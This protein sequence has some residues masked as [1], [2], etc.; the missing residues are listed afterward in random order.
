M[1]ASPRQRFR[2]DPAA[3]A[4]LDRR[5]LIL[6]VA[7]WLVHLAI[8]SSRAAV[9]DLQLSWPATEARLVTAVIGVAVCQGLYDLLKRVSGPEGLLR[10]ALAAGASVLA[11]VVFTVGD[12]AAFLTLVPMK[13]PWQDALKVADV[14]MT[15]LYFLIEFI[16]WAALYT[17]MVGAAL[18][19]DRE[20]RLALAESAAHKAQMSALRLQIQPHFLFNTLNTLSGLIAL[21]RPAEAE[22]LILNLSSLMRR[23]LAAA[24]DQMEP[25]GEEVR[26]Q[27]MYLAI[28]QARFPDRLQVRNDVAREC[29][30]AAVPSMILQPLV[31]NAVKHGL[32]PSDGVVCVALGAARSG[33]DLEIW[34]SNAP[35]PA[36]APA[37][38]F[39]IG[40]ENARQRLKALFG[41]RARLE[42]GPD[43]AGWTCR[44]F[45]PWAEAAR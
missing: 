22:K 8:M 11:C 33:E 34:V 5:M 44:I 15:Y 13:T 24:P 43:T 10:F 9:G 17:A 45:L 20:R 2:L 14:T 42:A 1:N 12:Y 23:T 25:L 37:P 41:E 30:G 38:G 28:E 31:E 16:A 39:G 7:F 21:D 36:G 26:N 4:G 19:R 35:S 6:N 32:A 3:Q 27:L 29:E 40:L 18:L